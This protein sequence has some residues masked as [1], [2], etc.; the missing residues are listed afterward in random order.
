LGILD[1]GSYFH[2]QVLRWA[3]HVARMP[4]SQAPRLY[5]SG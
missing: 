3:D 5:L 4:M 2:N 1:I